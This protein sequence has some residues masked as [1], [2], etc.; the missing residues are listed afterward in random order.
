[1]KL[2]ILIVLLSLFIIT[3]CFKNNDSLKI[4]NN[5]NQAIV[6]DGK[7]EELWVWKSWDSWTVETK[8]WFSN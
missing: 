7:I 2:N 8:N 3:W 4:D 1:M 5:E 6:R